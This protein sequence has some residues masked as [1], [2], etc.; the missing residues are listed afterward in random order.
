MKDASESCGREYYARMRGEQVQTETTSSGNSGKVILGIERDEKGIKRVFL[1][2]REKRTIF[3]QKSRNIR[4][5]KISRWSSCHFTL[6][7]F[8]TLCELVL[9]V[10]SDSPAYTVCLLLQLHS[11]Q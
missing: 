3:S 8:S 2:V 10:V 5:E 4:R 9:S 11:R 7:F 6:L 1:P